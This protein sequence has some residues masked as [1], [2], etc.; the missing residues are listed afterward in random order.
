MARVLII[1]DDKGMCY[2]LSSMVRLEGHEAKSVQTLKQGINECDA[3]S[4][5]V[6]LLDVMM[7][8]GSGLEALPR[9]RKS[10]SKPEVVI[11]T[12][13]GSADGAEMAINSGAWDYLQKPFAM[14]DLKLP[15][16]RALQYRK[17]RNGKNSRIALRREGIIGHSPEMMQ[18]ID[19][20]AQ[21]SMT[22]ANVLV[23]GE[24]GTGKE[25]VALAIHENSAHSARPFII[26]DCGALPENLAESILFGHERGAFTGAD[27][28]REGLVK[29]AHGG[30][31]FLD[32]IGELPLSMQKVF[33]RVIQERRFR[34][35][36]AKNEERS[37]FRL[38]AATNRDLDEIVKNGKFRKDLLF[39]LRSIVVDLPPLRKRTAD[40]PDLVIHY[41]RKLCGRYGMHMKGFSPEFLEAL[42]AYS[43]PGNVRELIHALERALATAREDQTLFRLHLPA[44]IRVRLAQRSV[45]QREKN[46]VQTENDCRS[47]TLPPVSLKA[48]LETTERSYLERLLSSSKG[49]MKEVCRISGLS[50]SRL[51]ERLKKIRMPSKPSLADDVKF[52]GTAF[53]AVN[54]PS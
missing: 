17:E 7:P 9:I 25:L 13:A 10:A 24:T 48:A 53:R 32:E 12:A 4:Y 21:A 34:P 39:R 45:L 31:L 27:R 29:L 42:L 23:T 35:V 26:V 8:D 15:L 22:E 30:T 19:M 3:G 28:Q 43:W 46:S 47:R 52:T 40:I 51:Y 37:D 11:M 41:I 44:S 5:D 20:I 6:V 36:G 2:T 54:L 16:I 38:I 49:N 50:R 14:R 33:L 18:C 1:D